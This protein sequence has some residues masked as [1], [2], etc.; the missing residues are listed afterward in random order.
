M[1]KILRAVSLRR[2]N[3]LLADE[4]MRRGKVLSS[5]LPQC[6]NGRG[7]QRCTV[8]VAVVPERLAI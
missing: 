8:P 2:A 6:K 3:I 4:I 1:Q 7:P 5:T